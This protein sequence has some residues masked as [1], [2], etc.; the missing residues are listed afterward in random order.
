MRITNSQT[1]ARPTYY[2]RNPANQTKYNNTGAVA[3]HGATQRWTYTVP[4][5]KKAFIEQI[6]TS[7]IRSTVAAPVGTTLNEV[8]LIPNGGGVNILSLRYMNT[9]GVN[10]NTDLHLTNLGEIN[11]GDQINAL[12]V[13]TSTG[14]TVTFVKTAKIQEFDA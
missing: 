2:D 12:D 10:D 4:A 5:G 7:I 6:M 1:A 13:D 3:P 9:N 14:G 11:A 8:D